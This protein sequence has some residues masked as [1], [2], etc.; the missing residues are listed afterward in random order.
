M[1]T[2]EEI[3]RFENEFSLIRRAVGWSSDKFAEMIGATRQTIS[4]IENKRF[5]LSKTN[6][7]ASRYVLDDEIRDHPKETEMLQVVLEAF[8]DNPSKYTDEQKEEIRDR[9]NMISSAVKTKTMTKK[10]GLE[11]WQKL[12]IAGAIST[13]VTGIISAFVVG[14]WKK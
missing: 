11:K 7:I 4:N 8:V 14:A 13:V 5:K 12:T 1:I 2:D 3:K 6:Y 10:E 9:V